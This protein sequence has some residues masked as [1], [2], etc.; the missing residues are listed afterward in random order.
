MTCQEKS[1][2]LRPPHPNGWGMLRAALPHTRF[3]RIQKSSS[4]RCPDLLIGIVTY[5]SPSGVWMLLTSDDEAENV[6]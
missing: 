6:V 3:Y 5:W 4:L 2:C 1:D